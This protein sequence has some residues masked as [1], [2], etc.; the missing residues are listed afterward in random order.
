LGVF[1]IGKSPEKAVKSAVMV[2][3]VAKT[4][5]LALQLGIANSLPEDEIK[6]AHHAYINLYGQK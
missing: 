5:F 6:R 1:T 4:T 2:E 3:D